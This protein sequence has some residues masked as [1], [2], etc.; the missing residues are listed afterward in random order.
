MKFGIVIRPNAPFTTLAERS[1]QA[2]ELGFDHLWTEDH[3]RD[4]VMF[5]PPDDELL[6]P[7]GEKLRSLR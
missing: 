3:S 4:F 6:A 7:V 1:R 2:E 5:W